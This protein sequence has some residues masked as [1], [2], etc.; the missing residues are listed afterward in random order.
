MV[1]NTQTDVDVVN[2]VGPD[3]MMQIVTA[4]PTDTYYLNGG[5]KQSPDALKAQVAATA[6]EIKIAY[7][8]NENTNAFTDVDDTKVDLITVTNP[9]NLDNL[10]NAIFNSSLNIE[11]VIANNQDFS[12][13][14]N[15]IYLVRS[16][17]VTGDQ[18]TINPIFTNLE[19]GN[20]FDVVLGDNFPLRLFIDTTET[21]M[22]FTRLEVLNGN[23]NAVTLEAKSH[24]RFAYRSLNNILVIP[25]EVPRE[26]G[27]PGEPGEATSIIAGNNIELTGTGTTIDPYVI[28]SNSFASSYQNVSGTEAGTPVTAVNGRFYKV[29]YSSFDTPLVSVSLNPANLVA[30]NIFYVAFDQK[31]A[32]PIALNL[33]AVG[34]QFNTIDRLNAASSVYGMK[35]G[36]TV[37]IVWTGIEFVITSITNTLLDE[38]DF[39]LNSDRH[40]ATQQSIK[41]YVDNFASDKTKVLSIVIG[42][43]FEVNA[44]LEKNTLYVIDA[45]P[46]NPGGQF[47][48]DG[49]NL[50]PGDTFSVLNV[51]NGYIDIS[52]SGTNTIGFTR[53]DQ[54]NGS[55]TS[56]RLPE[57]SVHKFH[58]KEVGFGTFYYPIYL[59]PLDEDDFVSNSNENT[60]TQQSIKAYV[61]NQLSVPTKQK[62]GK[63]QFFAKPASTVYTLLNGVGTFDVTSFGD[64]KSA[65]ILVDKVA[66]SLND[67][68]TLVIKHLDNTVNTWTPD[69]TGSTEHDLYI[70][71]FHIYNALTTR[72][73][74][75]AQ[76]LS[77]KSSDTSNGIVP[78]IEFGNG[79]VRFLF[80]SSAAVWS[81]SQRILIQLNLT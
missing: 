49:S 40:G 12:I 79:E 80:K 72:G 54:P 81:G 43:A 50:V 66:D 75:F 46:S 16:Q 30:G 65:S 47:K 32:D 23:S 8:S 24:Y 70:P 53:A 6:A 25:I 60:A 33:D 39:A 22:R 55:S 3:G 71:Q 51:V 27:E 63:A 37:M 68:F 17:G 29:T 44:V 28:A 11:T 10:G 21:S 45:S 20:V 69:A 5:K 34:T 13:Y 26:V 35:R 15:K 19:V 61:D 77:D 67:N 31:G 2:I 52:E 36:E 78:E 74:L 62:T 57:N 56:A 48:V 76:E 73:P 38:D 18:Q 59:E 4:E 1:T 41:A 7:E 58:V 14:P 64:L 42:D 9:I